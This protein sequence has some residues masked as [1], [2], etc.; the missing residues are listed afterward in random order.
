MDGNK[1]LEML[2]SINDLASMLGVSQRSLARWRRDGTGP[3]QIKIG[4]RRYCHKDDV[5][6]WIDAK[7]ED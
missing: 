5:Q 2:I 3:K 7:R 6:A 1:Q 4:R